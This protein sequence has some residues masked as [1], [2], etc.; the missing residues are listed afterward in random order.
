MKISL[1]LLAFLSFR[2]ENKKFFFFLAL[3]D[4]DFS[5]GVGKLLEAGLPH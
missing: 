3:E 2:T 5:V 4:C 1:M